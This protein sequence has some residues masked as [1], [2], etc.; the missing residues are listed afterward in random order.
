MV[1]SKDFY[2]NKNI[3]IGYARISTGKLY[4]KKYKS[5]KIVD[6]LQL[7]FFSAAGQTQQPRFINKKTFRFAP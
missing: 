4:G 7:N 5:F 6:S 1:G 3:N 2:N